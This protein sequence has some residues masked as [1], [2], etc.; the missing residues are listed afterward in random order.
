MSDEKD[1]KGGTENKADVWSGKFID[2][3]GR[4]GTI[5]IEVGHGGKKSAWKLTLPERG[6][7][8][9]HIRGETD[10]ALGKEGMQMKSQQELGKGQKLEWEIDLKRGPCG[11]YAQ[12]AMVGRYDV[13]AP[14]D[15]VGLP[16]TTGVMV[17]WKF[18]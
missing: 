12:E 11:S 9:G 2:A 5:E 17:L 18:K 6:G 16:L 13:R 3:N 8:P 15:A 10:I 4:T 14:K 1:Q 7:E